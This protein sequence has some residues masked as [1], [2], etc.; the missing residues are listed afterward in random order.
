LHA[1]GLAAAGVGAFLSQP[2]VITTVAVVGTT[3]T[4]YAIVDAY[5]NYTGP[6]T[7]PNTLNSKIDFKALKLSLANQ[8]AHASDG[9][10]QTYYNQADNSD[11]KGQSG[12]SAQSVADKL[13]RY[14]LNPAHP[15]GGSKAKFFEKALGFTRENA[16]DLAKQ[17][18]FNDSKA[19]QTAVT[20]YGTKFNQVIDIVGAN[21]RIIPVNTAW[22][23]CSLSGS[24]SGYWF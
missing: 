11:N 7:Q 24:F 8:A 6:L 13:E 12:A 5:Q 15:D 9:L 14:L 22:I 21:G 2:I 16:A 1:L 3:I 4:V 17:I 18:V 19:I 10:S 20:Q 23:R